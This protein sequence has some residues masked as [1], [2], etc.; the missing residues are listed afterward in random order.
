MSMLVVD[1]LAKRYGDTA[2][3]QDYANQAISTTDT[4]DV[5]WFQFGG[6]TYIVSNASNNASSF[7]NGT[8]II[9]RISGLVD[10]SKS[11]F[12]SSSDRLV[13]TPGP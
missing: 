11:A 13:Y 12:S 9:V 1:G 3:F 8:D 4:G 5:A 2:V 7:Q 6:N 10:L